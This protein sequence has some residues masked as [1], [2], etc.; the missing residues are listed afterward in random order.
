[1][2]QILGEYSRGFLDGRAEMT[3]DPTAFREDVRVMQDIQ[4]TD[5]ER[6]A[7][8]ERVMQEVKVQGELII[9]GDLLSLER[10]E[11]AKKARSRSVTYLEKFSFVKCTRVGPLHAGHVHTERNAI[12]KNWGVPKAMENGGK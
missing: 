2:C 12:L 10:V 11:C 7:A 8:E 5:E 9:H 3:N 4:A 1:M 6:K